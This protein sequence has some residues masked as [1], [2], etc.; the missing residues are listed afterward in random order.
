MACSLGVRAFDPCSDHGLPS[1]DLILATAAHLRLVFEDDTGVGEE[2]WLQRKPEKEPME[3]SCDVFL[4]LGSPLKSGCVVLSGFCSGWL[5]GGW[6]AAEPPLP[7][8][9]RQLLVLYWCLSH[10][11]RAFQSSSDSGRCSARLVLFSWLGVG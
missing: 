6:W 5:E 11:R 8:V 10:Q 9:Y 2:D 3:A 4:D 7:K 1:G